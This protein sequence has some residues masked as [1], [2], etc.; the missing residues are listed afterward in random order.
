MGSVNREKE[1][2]LMKIKRIDSAFG[3]TIVEILIAL[4][5]AGLVT[6]AAMSLYLT[7][8]KQL[9][10][11][12]EVSD[13]QANV[14][15]ATA[16]LADKIQMAGYR[17]PVGISPIIAHNTNPDT[18]ELTYSSDILQGCQIE[19]PMPQPSAELRCDGHDLTGLH[20][21]DWAYIYDP[22]TQTGE[23]FLVSEVQLASSNIQHNTMALSRAYP[24][25]SKIL[26]LENFK[27]YVDQTDL[28]HP[29]LMIAVRGQAPQIYADNIPDLEFSYI[30]SNGA[31]VEEP[32]LAYMIREVLISVD[33]RNNKQDNEFQTPYRNRTLVT[34][35]K[36]RNLQGS[37]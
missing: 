28:D 27:Y 37:E 5:L 31:E 17:M 24:A 13:M 35:V 15:A 4:F 25:G 26:K 2:M 30:L 6:S 12:E 16:E 3:F 7:Q 11:Q 34:R 14:R 10:I 33:A 20:D 18:I 29:N 8:Q 23:Y 22:S 1:S 9:N 32:P 21:G 19:W 36:V